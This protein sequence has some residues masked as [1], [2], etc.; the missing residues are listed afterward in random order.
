[1]G[2]RQEQRIALA[3]AR[4]FAQAS[5]AGG[6]V[7]LRVPQAPESPM[8]NRVVGLGTG[9]RATEADVD[10]ALAALGPGLSF[11][12]AVHPQARPPQL[13]DWLRARGLEP[14]WGWMA[15]RRSVADPP[16][17]RTAL[18]LAEV[19]DEDGA[20]A[21]ARI[22]R[23]GFGLPEAVEAPLARATAGGWRWWL[24]RDGDEPV[25][26]GG[27]FVCENAG[28]L[29]FGATLPEHRGKG[30]QGALL[31]ARIRR[32]AGLGCDVV[33]T[34]TG[35]RRGDRP[36]NSY[37]NIRRAGFEEIAVTANWAGRR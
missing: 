26:A 8:L 11:Y 5:E 30:A 6:A 15:F 36:S 34:E 22:V 35:E 7:V 10:E 1:M 33:F 18:S 14:G 3:S 29:G 12:V 4:A 27:L 13:P 23:I 21:V 17:A 31:A 28:Y 19:R 9:R 32:A 2:L 25:G 16:A 20:A 37:R 24:A